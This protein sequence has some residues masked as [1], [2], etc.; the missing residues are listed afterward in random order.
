MV[1]NHHHNLIQQA[2]ELMDSVWRYEQ[3]KKDSADCE[4]C[5]KLWDTL[6]ERHAADVEILKK[7]IGEHAQSGDW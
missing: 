1:P 5:R 7:H 2:S 6:H 4:D 3:Y